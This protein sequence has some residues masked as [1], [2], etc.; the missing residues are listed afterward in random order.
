MANSTDFHVT[1]FGGSVCAA[2]NGRKRHA[3]TAA[4]VNGFVKLSI[5]T[6]RYRTRA[7]AQPAPTSGNRPPPELFSFLADPGSSWRSVRQ[8][9]PARKPRPAPDPCESTY[10][11]PTDRLQRRIS[12][13]SPRRYTRG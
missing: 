5:F 1:F 12:Q 4:S 13:T 2:T 10:P 6:L 3:N 8:V 9:S 11:R 7:G